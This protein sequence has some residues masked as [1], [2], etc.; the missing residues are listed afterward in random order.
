MRGDG[1]EIAL[2]LGRPDDAVGRLIALALEEDVGPGDRTAE[3]CVPASL[4][5]TAAIV[6]KEALVVAGVAAAARVF[7]ALDGACSLEPLQRD[8]DAVDPGARVLRVRG[9]LRALLTAERT[10][11][12][13]LQ[14]LSGIATL[15]RRHADALAGTKT[16]LLDTRKTTP[17]MRALEKAAVRAGGGTNHRGALFDGILVKDNHAAAAGGIGEAVRRARAAAPPLLRVE[18]E[19]S[20]PEQIEEALAAGADMLLLDN[21]GDRELRAAV[22]QV[23]GRVPT[24]AS[25]GMT[26]ERLPRIAACGV[27]YVSV[28]ALT[29]SAPAVDLSLVVEART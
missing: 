23:R 2:D 24:E 13:L 25:G 10:A 11:L 5:G 9:S 16:K 18:A 21:L 3:A 12:N 19:V 6:A 28:G 26:L 7:R 17:G 27:D 14:R 22:A 8:G 29:H 4:R 1:E 20:T 15:T